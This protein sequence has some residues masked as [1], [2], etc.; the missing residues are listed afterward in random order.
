MSVYLSSF[1]F[2]IRGHCEH[3]GTQ[4]ALEDLLGIPD[5]PF[6]PILPLPINRKEKEIGK[7]K[8]KGKNEK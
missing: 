7:K 8:K 4:C 2:A 5:V 3:R 6:P 1:D